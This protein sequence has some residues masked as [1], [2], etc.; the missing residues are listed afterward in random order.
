MIKTKIFRTDFGISSGESAD[1]KCNKFI[2]ENKSIVP[3]DFRFSNSVSKNSLIPTICESI[4]L[5][6]EESVEE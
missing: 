5:I 4:L 1:K 2:E 3:I 6:Y